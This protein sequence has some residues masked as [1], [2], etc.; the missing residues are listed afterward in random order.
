MPRGLTPGRS[1][2]SVASATTPGDG[3]PGAADGFSLAARPAPPAP[4]LGRNQA[5][6]PVGEAAPCCRAA[7]AK[8]KCER[9][10][11]SSPADRGARPGS[12]HRCARRPE[13]RERRGPQR[14]VH[15]HPQAVHQGVPRHQPR[16]PRPTGRDDSRRDRGRRPPARRRPFSLPGCRP[17]RRC[18][19]GPPRTCGNEASTSSTRRRCGSPVA[20]TPT[21]GCS[22]A[23]ECC[24][25]ATTRTVRST[26]GGSVRC[27]RIAFGSGYDGVERRAAGTPRRSGAARPSWSK[28]ACRRSGRKA[29]C[30][31]RH[32]CANRG[33][34]RRGGAGQGHRRLPKW[35]GCG[36]RPPGRQRS[37]PTPDSAGNRF[38]A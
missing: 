29:G 15:P 5:P 20:G 34:G 33:R 27:P 6:R 19:N 18:G 24:G 31:G 37:L 16:A 28:V 22:N 35:C 25:T 3:R 7:R 4:R 23:T 13:R 9:R 14:T 8:G 26:P 17:V 12:D 38:A 30:A 10:T 36:R 11:R 21:S 2:P 1:T 32:G